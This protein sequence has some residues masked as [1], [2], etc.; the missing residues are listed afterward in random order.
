MSA[1]LA[2][3]ICH[4]I[5]TIFESCNI[6]PTFQI[7][8]VTAIHKKWDEWKITKYMP[9]SVITSLAKINKKYVSGLL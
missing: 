3:P 2:K 4:L 9:I 1:I 6:P 7:A 8:V 5:N